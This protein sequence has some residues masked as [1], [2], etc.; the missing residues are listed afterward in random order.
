MIR[1]IVFK[2]DRGK[3]LSKGMFLGVMYSVSIPDKNMCYTVH[4]IGNNIANDTTRHM[5]LVNNEHGV[6]CIKDLNEALKEVQ[7]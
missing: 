1:H 3:V 7:Y 4:L 6:T 5:S 2:I